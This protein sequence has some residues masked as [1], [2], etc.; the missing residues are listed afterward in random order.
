M[1]KK[2]LLIHRKNYVEVIYRRNSKA[3]EKQLAAADPDDAKTAE[4]EPAGRDTVF[5]FLDHPDRC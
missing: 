5:Q 2:R 3:P 4:K 1:K